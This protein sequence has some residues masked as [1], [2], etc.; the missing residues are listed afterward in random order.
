MFWYVD[1]IFGVDF[2]NYLFI[3]LDVDMRFVILLCNRRIAIKSIVF[4]CLNVLLMMLV[5]ICVCSLIKEVIR[6][7]YK[8]MYFF[9]LCFMLI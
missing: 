7:L 1:G 9:L 5:Y 3:L 4:V 2:Y 6:L 8:I